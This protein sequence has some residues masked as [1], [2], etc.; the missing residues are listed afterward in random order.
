MREGGGVYTLT[1]PISIKIITLVFLSHRTYFTILVC[2]ILTKTNCLLQI[3]FREFSFIVVNFS[4]CL[5][6]S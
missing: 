4:T 3:I 2:L 6:N 5:L 1:S